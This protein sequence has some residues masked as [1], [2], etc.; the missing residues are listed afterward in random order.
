MKSSVEKSESRET[1]LNVL[2]TGLVGAALGL[3]YAYVFDYHAALGVLGGAGLGPA[4]GFWISKRPPRMR[5]P[6][7]ML[8]RI[9]L[10]SFI[11]LVASF[12]YSYLL[13][14][15]LSHDQMFWVTLLPLVG[16]TGVVVAIGMAIA[17]LDELQRRIQTEAIAIGFAITAIFVAGY[18]LFQ[19]T[20]LPGINL[21]LVLL[22]MPGAWLV[23]KLWTLWRYR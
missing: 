10:A 11:M 5:Y 20:G 4:V 22:V 3:L 15:G 8:R 18:A 23:G 7:F 21:G 14:Q 1:L 9:L 17:S 16:W 12:V 6:I 19:F 2:I 13:I